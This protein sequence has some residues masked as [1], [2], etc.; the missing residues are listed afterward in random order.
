MNTAQRTRES[1]YRIHHAKSGVALRI[2]GVAPKVDEKGEALK[3]GGK[4]ASHLT[5][6]HATADGRA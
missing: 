4:A 3:V 2:L 6:L 5:P 1:S